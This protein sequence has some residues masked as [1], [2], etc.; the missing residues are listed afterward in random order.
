MPSAARE[1]RDYEARSALLAIQSATRGLEASYDDLS[2]EAQAS[3]RKAL[4]AEV[5]LLRQLVET[6]H[7][8]SQSAP[9]DVV[10]AIARRRVPAGRRARRDVHTGRAARRRRERGELGEIVQT[11]LDNAPTMPAQRPW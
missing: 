6:G 7:T 3:L 5:E 1:E 11:L 10:D 9:F 4:A 8:S 2:R